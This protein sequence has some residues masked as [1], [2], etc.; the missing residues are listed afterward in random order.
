MK[1]I[2]A[3]QNFRD[4][5]C[6]LSH[7]PEDVERAF[8]AEAAAFYTEKAAE[9]EPIFGEILDSMAAF[10][11]AYAGYMALDAPLVAG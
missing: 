11:K 4:F 5:G 6:D 3:V 10:G 7:L 8:L 1:C 9:E 2:V